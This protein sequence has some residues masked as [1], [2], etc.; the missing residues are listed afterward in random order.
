MNEGSVEDLGEATDAQ[1]FDQLLA[2]AGLALVDVGCGAGVTSRALAERGA[3]VLGVEPDPIQAE[4]NRAAAPVSG[5]SFAEAPAQ[6]LPLAAGSADG[7]F[8]FRSLHHV[9]ATHM[10]G[11]L[12]EALRVLKP[13]GGFLYVVEPEMTGTN[14]PLNRAFHDESLVRTQALA[15]LDGAADDFERRHAYRYH[16]IIHYADFEAFIARAVGA[17]F[18]SITRDM[19]DSPEVRA[20]FEV[21]RA[22]EGYDFDQP[23]ILHL[24]RRGQ[25]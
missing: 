14:F 20:L 7:V 19:V 16:R 4:K 18:N 12:E 22:S 25:A 23:M 3:T 6:G 5:L 10:A 17:S 8:F 21:G 24:Y 2:V 13:Q 11:A 15:A 1:A 9:P